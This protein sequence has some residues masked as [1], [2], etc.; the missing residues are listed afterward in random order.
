M[1][2]ARTLSQAAA[3]ELD[4]QEQIIDQMRNA[5]RGARKTK[6]DSES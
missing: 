4:F 6:H 2:L 1:E 3:M 5:E